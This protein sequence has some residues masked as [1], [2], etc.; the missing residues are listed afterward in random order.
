[1]E[2]PITFADEELDGVLVPHNDELVITLRIGE[3]DVKKIIVDQGA[4]TE[5]MYYHTFKKMEL[6]P[7][8]LKK[9]LVPLVDFSAQ[10]IWP[11]GKVTLPVRAG[12]VVLKTDFLV[13]DLPSSYNVIMRRTWMHKMKAI[14]YKYH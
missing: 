6:P 8:S 13:V 1:M 3:Y 4:S 12:S 9:C 5:I 14:P 10:I 7:S 11:M 2:T